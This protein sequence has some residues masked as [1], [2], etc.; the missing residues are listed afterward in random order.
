MTTKQTRRSR[1]RLSASSVV[2]WVE[3]LS[4][5]AFAYLL[6]SP[7]LLLLGSMAFYPLLRTLFMSFQADAVRSSAFAKGFVGLDHYVALL[8][9]EA[10]IMLIRPLLPT[11]VW[12][13]QFPFIHAVPNPLQSALVVTVVFAVVS[14]FFETLIGFAQAL[15]L[16]QE[17]QGRRWVRIAIIIPWAVP[18]AIQGMVF[19]LMFQPNIGFLTD[20]LSAIGI[21]SETPLTN[22]RDSLLIV[23]VGDIWKT[24][25]FM[26][27]L[28]LA[29]L[30]SIDRSLYE[31]SRVAGASTWERFR[32]ITLP[33]VFPTVMVAMLFR[34][35]QA[36][37]VYGLIESAGIGCSTVPSLS[38]LVVQTFNN[39][40]YALSSA[41]AFLTA[42]LIGVGVTVYIMKYA[43]SEQG[44]I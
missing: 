18:I 6:L 35:I 3:N 14:V 1:S 7:V 16:D 15:V 40:Y 39:S 11:V 27:L 42:L 30:Q 38:C 24:S 9:G 32:Y 29:G 37:R 44:G 34:T 10:D 22:T 20:P 28:I 23:I 43:D 21:F 31:V 2:R 19:L 13:S 17:F 36:L 33:L 8:T 4:D 5:T 12:N 25:A 26:A 41:I